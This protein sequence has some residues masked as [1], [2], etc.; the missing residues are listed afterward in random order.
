MNVNLQAPAVATGEIK[1]DATPD[2]IWNVMTD[3]ENWPAWNLDVKEV[4]MEG[5]VMAGTVF[6]WKSGP[7]WITST[8]Q[9]VERPRRLVWTGKTFGIHA[10]HV[11]Q[12]DKRNDH[13]VV[14]TEESWEGLPARLFPGFSRKTLARA[15][16]SGL[17]ALKTEAERRANLK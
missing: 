1:V 15:I 17:M 9:Q 12:I 3:F 14:K 8:L 7:G 2:I 13:S 5:P 11:W 10:I 16:Q 6:R 4:T